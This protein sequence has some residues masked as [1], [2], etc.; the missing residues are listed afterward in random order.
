MTKKNRITRSKADLQ[1]EL[2]DQ[3]SLLKNSCNSYDSGLEAIGKHIALILRVLFHHH[4]QSRSLLEQLGLRDNKFYDSAGPLNP[5]NL[6]S[7]IPLVVMQV[8]NEE[9][10]YLASCQ[11]GGS[12]YQ[13]KRI[14]FFEWWNEPII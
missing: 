2:K 7:D 4:G 12:P 14:K 10:I 8:S 6:L 11:V 13:P 5:N 1:Q 3:I 9:A